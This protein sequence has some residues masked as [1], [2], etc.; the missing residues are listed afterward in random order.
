M[1][2]PERALIADLQRDGTARG[3][4]YGLLHFVNGVLSLPAT[5]LAAILWQRLGP[6]YAFAAGSALALLAVAVLT[7]TTRPTP[8][9]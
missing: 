7:L 5:I 9:H 2:G 4:A 3:S 8:T 6:E 1:E